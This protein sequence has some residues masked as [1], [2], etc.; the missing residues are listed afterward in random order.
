M[1]SNPFDYADADTPLH[2]YIAHG[3][4][5]GSRPGVIVVPE[6]PGITEHVKRRVQMLSDLGYVAMAVDLYG[7]G[8]VGRDQTEVMALLNALRAD[9]LRWRKRIAAALEALRSHPLVDAQRMA[10]IGYC[11]GGSSVLE[12]ARSGADLRGVVCLH[13]Q[14]QKT[15]AASHPIRAKVLVCQAGVDFFTTREHVAAF[16][17]E[18]TAAGVDWQINTYGGSKHGF[19][20]RE[21]DEAGLPMLGYQEAADRRSWQATQAF[22]SEALAL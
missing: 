19:T 16:E 15:A 7:H 8:R 1:T 22:L 3:A 18:M 2:G 21:A 12:L 4:N 6:A 17:D 11:F 5:Q 13:G 10:A 14:L 20:S 9:V